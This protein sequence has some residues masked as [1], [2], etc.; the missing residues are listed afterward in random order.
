MTTANKPQREETKPVALATF[1]GMW[2]LMGVGILMGISTKML[3]TDT[4]SS[5]RAETADQ[6]CEFNV[7]CIRPYMEKSF[8]LSLRALS[9]FSKS[10]M[11]TFYKIENFFK[12]I[13]FPL[14]FSHARL[15]LIILLDT[16]ARF[17][18]S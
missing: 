2:K 9:L 18:R 15:S 4:A 16:R 7:C 14:T 13:P 8:H 5:L 11:K 6:S 10:S 1:E 17:A 3:T 12:V